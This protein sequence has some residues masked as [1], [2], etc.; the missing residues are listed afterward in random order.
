LI[1]A[2]GRTITTRIPDLVVTCEEIGP[3]DLLLREPLLIMEILSPSNVADTRAAVVRDMSMA[4]VQEIVVPHS[5]ETRAELR[6]RAPD[7]GWTHLMLGAD[8][9]VAL[10]SIGL[11]V[12]LAAFYRTAPT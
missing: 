8:D 5:T 7:G 9:D 10:E 6:R 3:D 1:P 4:S 12:S 2:S 11:I